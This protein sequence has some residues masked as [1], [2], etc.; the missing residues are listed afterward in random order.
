M[1]LTELREVFVCVTLSCK[2][3][4]QGSIDVRV[5]IYFTVFFRSGSSERL[6]RSDTSQSLL[7]LPCILPMLDSVSQGT[8]RLG[9]MYVWIVCSGVNVT[10]YT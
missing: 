9:N 1:T 10:L 7:H 6:H 3:R 2:A 5:C 8:A 4:E